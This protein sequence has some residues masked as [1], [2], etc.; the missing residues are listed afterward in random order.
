MVVSAVFFVVFVTSA[1]S[2]TQPEG[3]AE[4]Q[5]ALVGGEAVEAERIYRGW[6][7]R[8]PVSVEAYAGLADSLAAQKRTPEALSMLLTTAEAWTGEGLHFSSEQ[9]LEQATRL[10]PAS[11][12][13]HALLGRARAL[14]RKYVSAEGPL[15][16]AVELG[17]QDL[18]T[19]LYLGTTLWENGK[20]SEAEDIYRR[21]VAS[22]W[23]A[24]L[25]LYQL[26]RLLLWQGRFDE[27]AELLR[28]AAS[29]SAGAPDIQLALAR[30]LDGAG[31]TEEA[32]VAYRRVTG[33]LPEHAQARYGLALLLARAGDREAADRELATYLGLYE[34]EQK[35]TREEGLQ[36][37]LVD[38]GSELLRAGQIEQAI[39]HLQ[40]LPPTTDV[41]AALAAAYAAAGRYT[42]AIEAL[43]KA[44]SSSPQRGDLRSKLMEARLDAASSP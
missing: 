44:V 29:E 1:V 37:A 11:S 18:R 41:L 22:S 36:R 34:A 6:I 20:L 12:R 26:G 13:A 14:Q 25:P 27:A 8:H 3:L 38:R 23:R 16:K 42:D 15:W 4:A 39:G 35:R 28:E 30:A 32:V 5:R 9:L 24:V 2:S 19:L 21:A 33:L 17:S 40:G 10:A 31:E 43:E 7:A